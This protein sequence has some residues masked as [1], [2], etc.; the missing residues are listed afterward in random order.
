MRIKHLTLLTVLLTFCTMSAFAQC[1][2]QIT[3]GQ[4]YLENF[5]S[6]T[7]ECWTVEATGNGT[8]AVMN[9]TATNV[10][11]FQ[12]ASAGDEARLISP[13]FDLSGVSGA[14]FSF[15][16]TMM[17][18][19]NNDV[20]TASYRTSET[21]SWHDLDSY[22]INDWQNT[23]EATF[24][25]P[26]ISAT[27][28]ISFLGHSNG[29]YYIFIDNVEIVGSGGCARPVNLEATEIT[30]FSA[31]LGWSTTGNEESWVVELNGNPRTVDTEPFLLEGLEPQTEYTFRV[32]ANCG[33]M[34]SEWSY[35][36]TFK[37]LCDVIIVTDDEP[38]FDDFE[39]SEDFICW[40]DE[41]IVGDYGWAIDPGYLVL[42]N[43]ANFFWMG[44]EALLSSAPLD[45]T[46]VTNPTLQFRHKQPSAE[47]SD[48]LYVAYRTSP[49]AQWQTLAFYDYPS[50]D[51][52]AE[53]ITLPEVS[54]TLQIG[55]DAIASDGNGNGVYV[56]DVWVGHYQST[57]VPS[58][59]EVVITDGDVMVYDLF[60]RQVATAKYRNG[61][62]DF[63]MSTLASG[64]YVVRISSD[65]GVM[66]RKIVKE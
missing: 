6:G 31:L 14:T 39:G 5:D 54:E 53:V 44:G 2:I 15:S 20:L 52:E 49:D 18:L 12:N 21:D 29:G 25:L 62:V 7:M 23:F 45:I 41:I 65:R 16:Y 3:D 46:A 56:D 33:G 50:N 55:F 64:V 48:H 35:P 58:E 43:T 57:G 66:T 30:A 60:G 9:G 40:Q 19:Y 38:Y 28:Q 11:A 32:K 27:Y 51:W 22:S 63:D 42:N 4:P 13:T 24:D 59:N 36:A 10:A 17:A 47:D 1:V 26:D 8:W 34:E 61:R 37:T